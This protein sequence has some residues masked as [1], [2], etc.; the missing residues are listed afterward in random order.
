MDVASAM[1]TEK[2]ESRLTID[3][4]AV[5]DSMYSIQ[6]RLHDLETGESSLNIQESPS[7][8]QV[9]NSFRRM[10]VDTKNF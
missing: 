7:I 4:K 3:L 2:V 6:T 5:G 1:I 8:P 9:D 10:P